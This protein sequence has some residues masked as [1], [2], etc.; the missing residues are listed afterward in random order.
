MASPDRIEW[1]SRVPLH[2][3]RLVVTCAGVGAVAVGAAW[4]LFGDEPETLL[5]GDVNPLASVPQWTLVSAAV[6]VGLAFVGVVRRPTV[7][8]THYALSV[9]PGAVRTLL[10]PWVR[11]AEVVTAPAG[12][13]AYLLIRLRAGSDAVGDRPTW[14]DQAVLR[15]ARRHSR[16]AAQYQLAVRLS[17][18]AGPPEGKL[19]A[20]AA[21]A[22]ETVYIADQLSSS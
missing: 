8:A 18:F 21:F 16:R 12:G 9:R 7:G 11:V 20:L 2:A 10:L 1:R 4:F 22:P 17:D 14:P 13:E 19:P 3:L 15:A 5:N 6:V